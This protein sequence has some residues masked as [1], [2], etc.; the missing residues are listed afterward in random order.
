MPHD[1]P[2]HDSSGLPRHRQDRR[3]PAA[4]HTPDVETD[5]FDK[6]DPLWDMLGKAPMA[7][8]DPWLAAR[9]MARLRRETVEVAWW[10]RVL[11][12]P[13]FAF[14]A[15]ALA[16]GVGLAT[17]MVLNPGSPTSVAV[18]AQQPQTTPAEAGAGDAGSRLS[19]GNL[20]EIASAPDASPTLPP[21]MDE[22]LNYLVASDNTGS[23]ELDIWGDSS[24]L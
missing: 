22:A 9:T 15:L 2:N 17:G 8:P 20:A 11:S 7:P 5:G 6:S 21:D 19:T 16:L 4:A 3:R 24:D 18:V 1:D 13:A 12:A 23:M 14:G 10:Q